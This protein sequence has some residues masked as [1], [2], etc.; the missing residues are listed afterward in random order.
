VPTRTDFLALN[1]FGHFVPEMTEEYTFT[2]ID[3]ADDIDIV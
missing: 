3:N 1:H 2:A